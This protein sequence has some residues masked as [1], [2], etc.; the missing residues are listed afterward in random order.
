MG[1]RL[2]QGFFSGCLELV[3][4]AGAQGIPQSAPEEAAR[5]AQT[6]CS[7]IVLAS[8]LGELGWSRGKKS[9]HLVS[10]KHLK[11]V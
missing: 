8:D 2:C 4:A 11:V 6:A 3:L 7:A 1:W 9:R 5:P 10:S